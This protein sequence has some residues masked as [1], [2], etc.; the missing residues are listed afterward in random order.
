MSELGGKLS[1]KWM[2]YR[3]ESIKGKRTDT[4]DTAG[5]SERN[6]AAKGLKWHRKSVVTNTLNRPGVRGG[7]AQG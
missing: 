5:S 3:A 1:P 4:A 6:M 7:V 2:K